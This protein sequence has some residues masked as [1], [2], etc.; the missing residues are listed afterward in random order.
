[1]IEQDEMVH[2]RK[3]DSVA[4]DK[5]SMNIHEAVDG[6]KAVQNAVAN[7]TAPNFLNI[8]AK[9]VSSATPNAHPVVG[10]SWLHS[11][12]VLFSS[13]NLQSVF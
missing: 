2:D 4:S 9:L 1:M 3:P 8:F 12:N 6:H 11:K 10:L 5:E 7:G 13:F